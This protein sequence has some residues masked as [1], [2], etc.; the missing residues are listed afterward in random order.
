M[1]IKALKS[2]CGTVTM[3]IGEEKE[4][5][6]N[7]AVGLIAAGY[8]TACVEDRQFDND[9]LKEAEANGE[10]GQPAETVSDGAQPQTEEPVKTAKRSRKNAAE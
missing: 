8:A 6:D 2:F 1:R 5:S 10:T 4:I 9:I 3:G 7:M